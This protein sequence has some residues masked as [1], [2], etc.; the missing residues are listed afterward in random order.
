MTLWPYT[1]HLN[2]DDVLFTFF[3]Y[4]YNVVYYVRYVSFRDQLVYKIAWFSSKVCLNGL[5]AN[6][7][8]PRIADN[9]DI[10][11]NETFGLWLQK[12]V[13]N[14]YCGKQKILTQIKTINKSVLKP[15]IGAIGPW[16]ILTCCKHTYR[17]YRD[18]FW[19]YWLFDINPFTKLLY[20]VLFPEVKLI[21]HKYETIVFYLRT[22]AVAY[23]CAN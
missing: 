10:K 13:V 1:S 18:I 15:Q 19:Y 9:K 2:C 14:Y 11:I 5:I 23:S 22:L 4:C 7:I 6:K 21:C 8:S 20:P 16:Y 3:Y 17:A 12:F